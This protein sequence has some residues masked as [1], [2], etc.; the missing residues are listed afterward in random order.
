MFFLL[1][2]SEQNASKLHCAQ[3]PRASETLPS[4]GEAWLRT[5]HDHNFLSG[6]CLK[7]TELP[8]L[9]EISVLASMEWALLTWS[10]HAFVFRIPDAE[11][12]GCD[13][14]TAVG[15][16]RKRRDRLR[17]GNQLIPNLQS[18]CSSSPCS[19]LHSKPRK[20]AFLPCGD[21]NDEFKGCFH[22]SYSRFL[23]VK[24]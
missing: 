4:S 11:V 12:P 7:P 22:C 9:C 13:R 10:R 17:W 18:A 15:G 8:G 20:Y 5:N 23:N 14:W 21:Q 6:A 16:S 24:T 1:K 19:L 3:V 2:C